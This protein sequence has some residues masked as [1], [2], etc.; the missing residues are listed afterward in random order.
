M[1]KKK[2]AKLK[3]LLD[4]MVARKDHLPQ[5]NCFHD[6]KHVVHDYHQAGLSDPEI[7]ELAS[8]QGRIIITKNV[9][10]FRPLAIKKQVGVIGISDNILPGVLDDLLFAKLHYWVPSSKN[11]YYTTIKIPKRKKLQ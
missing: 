5:T 6:L 3:L 7:A 4:E 9:K 10:H 1:T 11:L 8:K 2:R